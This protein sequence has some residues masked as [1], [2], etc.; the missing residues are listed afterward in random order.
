MS[1]EGARIMGRTGRMK[2]SALALAA[3]LLTVVLATTASN[4]GSG[5][6]R[7]GGKPADIV[8]TDG[9]N[10]LF[11][12]GNADVIVGR[13]G[14]DYIDGGKGRDRICGNRG[15]DLLYGRPGSDPFVSGGR[16]DDLVNGGKGRDFCKGGFGHDRKL[17]C[18]LPRLSE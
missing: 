4:A 3:A 14:D 12:T 13:R 10:I 6:P 5:Q 2:A 1:H 11:G 9:D 15:G 7:C 8:G 16:G 18:E 17:N